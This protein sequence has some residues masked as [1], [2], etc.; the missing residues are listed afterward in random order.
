MEIYHYSF[1][2]KELIGLSTAD[3][4]PMS[5]ED[6]LIPANATDIKPP[7]CENQQIACFIG[8][9]WIVYDDYRGFVYYTS[10]GEQH[11]ITEIGVVPPSD[12]L[13]EKPNIPEPLKTVFTSLEFFEL[14]TSD[15]QISVVERTLTSATIKL[16]YDKM[17]AADYI[18]LADERTIAGLNALVAAD[19]ITEARKNQILAID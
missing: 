8:N 4:D 12:A 10:D 6:F 5:P 9:E 11:V 1:L 3:T 7:V 17:L 19:L 2:T 16:W 14:F 13:T 18:N 15:E